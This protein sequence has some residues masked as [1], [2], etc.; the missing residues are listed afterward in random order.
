M[1]FYF[2]KYE[3]RIPEPP[4]AHNPK[5]ELVWQYFAVMAL[6]VGAWYLYWRWTESLNMAALWYAVPLVLAET[7]AYIGLGLF[8]FNLWKVRDTEPQLAPHF[9]NEVVSHEDKKDRIINVDVY[10]PT[11]DEDPELVRLSIQDAKKINNPM[12]VNISIHVLDDGSREAMEKVSKEEGVNYISRPDN[13][14]YKAGNLRNAMEQTNGDF[15]VICDADTRPFPTLLE[16]TLG[17]FRDTSVAWVQTPQWFFDIPEGK[18]LENVLEKYLSKTGRFLGK[19]IQ[20]IVGEIRVGEDPFVNDPKMFYDVIQRRRNWCNGSFCCGAGSIHRREA[21]MEAALKGYADQID[22]QSKQ[23][24]KAFAKSMGV[25]TLNETQQRQIRQKA[26]F[27]N[28]FTPYKF[29]VS[30]DIYTSIVLHSD[31]DR[32]WKS[33]MHPAVE[34]KMLSPQDLLTWTIQRFKYAG[35]TLDITKNDNPIF[36]KGMSLPRRLMYAATIWSYLGG[37]W[38]AMFLIAPVVYLFTAISPV[39]S[40]SLDFYVHILPFLILTEIAFM[41]GGWGLKGYPSK[42]SYLAFFPTN[43][44]ALW[45][46]MQGKTISFPVTPK[47]RQEGNF[48]NLAI[49]QTVIVILTLVGIAYAGTQ[50]ALGTGNYDTNGLILNTFWGL[51][52]ILALSSIIFAAFWKPEQDETAS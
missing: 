13:T 18:P 19:G 36:R 39:A 17:Y 43:L 25:K 51:N 48:I 41:L 3:N 7:G 38:N 9:L 11:Y 16:N 40:F 24:E 4:L 26:L 49:P 6:I 27:E 14:G 1:G 12:Q 22:K 20:K 34:S 32:N 44:R 47:S 21:I 52:N 29:H 42:A 28:E 50:L 30:E 37:I 46:V 2:D 5:L 10:F 35:G 45:T 33:V 8:I 31:P 23:H 15:L